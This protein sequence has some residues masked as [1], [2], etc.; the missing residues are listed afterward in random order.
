[1]DIIR[2][3]DI[4]RNRVEILRKEGKRIGFVPT[5]G[6]FHEGHLN[7]MRMSVSDCDVTIVSNYINPTQFDRQDDLETYPADIERD[8]AMAEAL[9]VDIMFYPENLYQPDHKTWVS[10]EKLTDVL[11]GRSRPGHFRGVATIVCK[12]FNIVN[13]HVT[14]FGQKDAQQAAVIGQMIR[15]LNYNI[16]LVLSPIIRE[17][18]GLALSSRNVRLTP[19][20]RK[21]APV[22][23]EKLQI[24]DKKILPDLSNK[25][26]LIQEAKKSIEAIPGI[27]VDYIDIRSWP[28]LGKPD[29][30]T[31]HLLIAGAI[32]MG[33]VRLIDNIIKEL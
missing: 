33:K 26:D 1:M 9:G 8:R 5:M 23:Y 17:P 13:P 28:D 27:R 3:T 30:E 11:C 25:D 15:D 18:D 7:L 29:H 22:L 4:L 14:Y 2:E 31:R 32:F 16:Q 20:H 21:K 12:L 10:T 24:I 6:Y 19:E